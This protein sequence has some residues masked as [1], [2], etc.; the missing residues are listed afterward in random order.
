MVSGGASKNFQ[1]KRGACQKLRREGDHT[2]ICTGLR[3]LRIFKGK[4]GGGM[5]NFSEIM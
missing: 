4:L 3:V 2:S 1:A 5:Q